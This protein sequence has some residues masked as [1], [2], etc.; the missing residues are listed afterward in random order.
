[1]TLPARD[2]AAAATLEPAAHP[3]P[4]KAS[5]LETGWVPLAALAAD[6]GPWRELAR[7]ALE[8]N[9]FL[10][11]AFAAAAAKH[12]AGGDVGVVTVHDGVRLVGLWPGRVE[13]LS[14][15]RPIPTFVAWTHPFA[16]LSTP[17][18]DG[19]TDS[20]AV[21]GAM[22]ERLPKLPGAPRL[23]LLPLLAEQGLVARLIAAQLERAGRAPYRLAGHERAALI[24]GRDAAVATSPK[25]LKE[26][27][28]QRRQLAEAG[29][30]LHEFA[31]GAVA[32]APALAEFFD[33]EAAGW[34]GRSGSAA[35][36]DLA[37]A[38]FVTEAVSMLAAER[39]A[40]IDLLKLAGTTIAATITLYSGDRAWFW[41]T[42][43]D[44]AF[45]RYS[46]GVQIALDLTEALAADRKLTLVDS[47][48]VADHPMIDRLWSG[49]IALADWLVPLD[50]GVSFT[51]GIAVERLR[52]AAILSLKSARSAWAPVT[53]ARARVAGLPSRLWSS[54]F[55]R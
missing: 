25:R 30:C 14:H 39:K 27:R 41:K 31:E 9:V 32:I 6:P 29:A 40:R 13:G 26:L 10:E 55:R 11:P 42:G 35:K 16:P 1:M 24:P 2:A 12:F 22:L 3:F 54:A 52:R 5:A 47:C 33:V 28:R 46:P 19:E 36:H 48:A 8:P 21:V 4:E 51:A 20:A 45:A 49:R 50:G 34:K 18:V 38:R 7:R 15:G 23:A 17:L 43:F 53:H 37:A 44:E